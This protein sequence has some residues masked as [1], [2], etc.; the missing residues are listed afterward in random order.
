MGRCL[1]CWVQ[2]VGR[3]EGEARVGWRAGVQASWVLEFGKVSG[4]VVLGILEEVELG[5]CGGQMGVRG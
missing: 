3:V 2:A 5:C 1:W 4:S